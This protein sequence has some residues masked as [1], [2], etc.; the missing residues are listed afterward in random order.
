MLQ[1]HESYNTYDSY[2]YM[3]MQK[4]DYRK[5]I[6]YYKKGLDVL[7]MYPEKNDL[8]SV[9]KDSEQALVYIKEMLEKIRE[10]DH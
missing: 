8:I 1:F 4:G 6:D 9:K 2:A 3:L 7:K 10:N 5:S